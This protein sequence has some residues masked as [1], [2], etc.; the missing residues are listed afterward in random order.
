MS[1]ADVAEH[2]MRTEKRDADA[3]LKG[4]VVALKNAKDH[5]AVKDK[6]KAKE[7]LEIHGAIGGSRS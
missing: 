2:L 1:P 4:L 3:C 6:A 7:V 5:A